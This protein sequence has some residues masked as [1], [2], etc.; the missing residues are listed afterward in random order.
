MPT[1]RSYWPSSE[2]YFYII[3]LFNVI[4]FHFVLG[5]CHFFVFENFKNNPLHIDSERL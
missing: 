1:F 3:M 5:Y 4:A 2:Q